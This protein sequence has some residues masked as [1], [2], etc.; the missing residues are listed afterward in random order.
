MASTTDA[1]T[2]IDLAAIA[3]SDTGNVNWTR[4]ELL[5]WLNMAQVEMVNLY[6]PSN[7]TNTV[8]R[9]SAG[10]RQTL[11]TDSVLLLDVPYNYLASGTRTGRL[12]ARTTKDLINAR[13]PEWTVAISDTTVKCFIYDQ[14]NPNV[15]YVY[16]PQ[17][18]LTS[19]VELVYAARPVAIANSEVG[20]KITVNDKYQNV[21]LNLLLSKAFSKDS[22]FGNN[23]NKAM[24]YRALAENELGIN[25][26]VQT[27]QSEAKA[28]KK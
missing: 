24:A 2:I 14:G 12:I 27:S 13:I 15:F 1:K 16:P 3:L 11:P 25:I 28:S 17:P 20:T 22:E 5:S 23:D 10:V 4:A 7:A 21:L 9:L 8:F 6:P 19:Y 26:P 18:A